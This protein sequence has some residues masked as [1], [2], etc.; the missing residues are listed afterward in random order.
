MS[1]RLYRYIP[2]LNSLTPSE[3]LFKLGDCVPME[4]QPNPHQTIYFGQIT[5]LWVERW[6]D[7]P[8]EWVYMVEYPDNHPDAEFDDWDTPISESLILEL[9]EVYGKLSTT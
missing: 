2:M 7:A 5:G 6:S 8:H 4:K 3:P 1:K 9:M